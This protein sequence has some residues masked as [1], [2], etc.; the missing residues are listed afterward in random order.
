MVK[1][2]CNNVIWEVYT[3]VSGQGGAPIGPSPL[4]KMTKSPTVHNGHK[5][6]PRVHPA[7]Q[8]TLN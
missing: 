7:D 8:Q 5:W 4:L 6:S 3:G 1:A 2:S